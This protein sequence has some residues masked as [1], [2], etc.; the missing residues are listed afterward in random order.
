MKLRALSLYNV[1]KHN[2]PVLNHLPDGMTI[3]FGPNEAGKS[4]ILAGLRG[5]LFGKA[6]I[7]ENTALI[8]Q[9]ARG[10]ATFELDGIQGLWRL[11][12]ALTTGGRGRPMLTSPTGESYVGDPA[13]REA[14]PVLGLVED[15]I[16][17]SVFTFQLAELEGI[18]QL[19]QSLHRRIYTVGMLGSHSPVEIEQIFAAKAR[20]IFSSDGRARNAKLRQCL[21]KLTEA[22][23][24]EAN[25]SDTPEAYMELTRKLALARDNLAC[26]IRAREVEI[27]ARRLR[28]RRDVEL[29]PIH[30]HIVLLTEE[31]RQFTEVPRI[32]GAQREIVSASTAALEQV[33][34]QLSQHVEIYEARRREHD[35]IVI[36]Q[37]AFALATELQ[38]LYRQASGVEEQ[39]RQIAALDQELAELHRA[40]RSLRGQMSPHM[41][42]E[43]VNNAD[44]GSV[45]IDEAKGFAEQI[46]AAVNNRDNAAQEANRCRELAAPA[47]SDLPDSW[48]TESAADLELQSTQLEA[49]LT[50]LQND[51]ALLSELRERMTARDR[52]LSDRDG[53]EKHVAAL[54]EYG[55]SGRGAARTVLAIV[56]CLLIGLGV[57]ALQHNAVISGLGTIVVGLALFVS[58]FVW[59][60]RV[61]PRAAVDSAAEA[62]REL[63]RCDHELAL[64]NTQ[65]GDLQNALV[66]VVVE[67]LGATE[68]VQA[69]TELAVKTRSVE[70]ERKNLDETRGRHAR[71]LSRTNEYREAL[72]K[73]QRTLRN[74][75]DVCESWRAFLERFNLHGFPCAVQPFL[76]EA[77][78]VKQWRENR[79]DIEHKQQVREIVTQRVSG[80]NE[81]VQRVLALLSDTD[82]EGVEVAAAN[83]ADPDGRELDAVFTRLKTGLELAL[84]AAQEAQ[85]ADRKRLTLLDKLADSERV[86]EAD[87]SARGIHKERREQVLSALGVTTREEFDQLD[88]IHLDRERLEKE[89]QGERMRAYGICGGHDAYDLRVES[90]SGVTREDLDA[91]LVSAEAE[92]R[93]CRQ[94]EEACIQDITTLEAELRS[95]NDGVG[96]MDAAWNVATLETERQRLARSWA[97]YRTAETLMRSARET[98]ERERQPQ[99]IRETTEIFTRVTQGKYTQLGINVADADKP[100]LICTD[101]FQRE[102]NVSQLSRG[103]KEQIYLAMRLALIRDYAQRELILPIVLDDPMVNFDQKRLREYMHILA[104]EARA[105]QM[106][107][108]TCHDTVLEA[109]AL[110]QEEVHVIH[111][112]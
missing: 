90:L 38:A 16:Y 100:E 69:Q 77:R 12:R 64:L 56:S 83:A 107:Y 36:D 44:F 80:F 85:E 63:A 55:N 6:I 82:T 76:E 92:W 94:E 42:D 50:D 105:R 11:E 1:G 43:I 47:R 26:D 99:A 28:L 59:V 68:C 70:A 88:A 33:E 97:V 24:Q 9:S 15:L 104:Q 3:V 86:I 32:T 62:K 17:R 102:W 52:L 18:E 40:S 84:R 29:Y 45:T 61:Q 46:Q 48:Q 19:N 71:W 89:L 87:R 5:V 75:E 53:R 110:E 101:R 21:A 54:L 60:R 65:I 98:F 34:R 111:L 10:T 20:D 72:D 67:P 109:A 79:G 39:L 51:V 57:A 66:H 23:A 106:I 95:W 30:Q 91:A 35:G 103:T 4:T 22:R 31:L 112:E 96:A 58:G 13:I 93:Q 49:D 27:D 41:T 108:L 25:R 81:S 74:C 8:G 7:A 14:V 37:Q 2:G 78:L 73:Q